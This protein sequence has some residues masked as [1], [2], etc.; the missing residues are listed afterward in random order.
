MRKTVVVTFVAEINS[1]ASGKPF[2]FFSRKKRHM[3]IKSY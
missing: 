2:D 1:A 3:H